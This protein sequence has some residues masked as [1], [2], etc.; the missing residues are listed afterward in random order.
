MVL[1]KVTLS[2]LTYYYLG[3]YLEYTE[4]LEA[5][6]YREDT[7]GASTVDWSQCRVHACPRTGVYL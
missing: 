3:K 7:P 2:Q 5:R 6:G 1:R 4:V